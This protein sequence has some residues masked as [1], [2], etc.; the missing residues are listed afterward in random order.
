MSRWTTY[1]RIKQAMEAQV[2]CPE[3]LA[4]LGSC[5]QNFKRDAVH[6]AIISYLVQKI[7]TMYCTLSISFVDTPRHS[8]ALPPKLLP[9]QT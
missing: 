3:T 5:I 6:L 2:W 8:A 9:S 1:A 4:P 7:W